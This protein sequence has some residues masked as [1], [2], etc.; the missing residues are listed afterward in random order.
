MNWL[1]TNYWKKSNRLLASCE[2]LGGYVYSVFQLSSSTYILVWIELGTD[3]KTG[4]IRILE[5]GYLERYI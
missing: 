2:V 1:W 5:I 4:F 3:T